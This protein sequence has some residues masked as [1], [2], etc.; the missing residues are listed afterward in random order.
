[1]P[2]ISPVV[3]ASFVLLAALL[4]LIS[5]LRSPVCRVPGSWHSLF[6]PILLRWH[7]FCARRTSYVHRTHQRYGPVV[8]IAPD[9]VSFTSAEAIKEIYGS[10]GSGYDKTEFYD[11][12]KVFGRRY[13][14]LSLV[15]VRQ[16]LLTKF[17]L[18]YYV[19]HA[20]QA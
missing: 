14:W 20:E 8:R 3:L 12:F 10:G 1:M 19:H 13:G 17:S 9:E 15:M 5:R 2:L 6:S 4:H 18:Q 7:E 16:V 11:M